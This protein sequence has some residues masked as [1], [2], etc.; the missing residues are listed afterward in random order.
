MK[1]N[2]RLNPESILSQRNQLLLNDAQHLLSSGKYT[3]SRLA[4]NKILR[5][6]PEHTDALLIKYQIEAAE[7]AYDAAFD[8]L[9]QLVDKHDLTQAQLLRLAAHLNKLEL[10]FLLHKVIHKL[11]VFS[12]EDN[13]LKFQQSLCLSKIGQIQ[14]SLELAL[15]CEKNDYENPLLFLNIGHNY[16]AFGNTDKAAEYYQKYITKCPENS[17]FGNWGL[18]DLKHYLF[19]QTE[20]EEMENKLRDV[21]LGKTENQAELIHFA[22][23]HAK[24]QQKS[25]QQALEHITI[26]NNGLSKLRPFR[27]QGYMQLINEL[28]NYCD[29]TINPDFTVDET[30][31]PI[32]IVGMPRSGTTLTEQILASHSKIA[33]TDEL[34]FI[35][36]I[37]MQM[38]RKRGYA[39]G[40]SEMTSAQRAGYIKFYLSQA[41]AYLDQKTPFLID[42][43]PTN[44]LHLGL[45][46]KLF[47]HAKIINLVRDPFDNAISVYKQHFSQG[48]DFSYDLN[49]IKHYVSGYIS[50][51]QHWTKLFPENVYHLHYEKL[52]SSPEKSISQL[53]EFCGLSIE[54]QCFEFFNSDK[55]V[56]TPS[57][58]QVRQPIHAKSLGSAG[59]YAEYLP[60]FKQHMD[61]LKHRMLDAFS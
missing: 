1:I 20:I 3:S 17:G 15:I 57:A 9:T 45:I 50:I 12:P 53:I 59:V 32:F 4:L 2:P 55:P 54:R 39:Q 46:I 30:L 5:K 21:N 42:K 58:S 8:Q 43:N 49:S 34:P 28:Q 25:Y 61:G 51:M 31:T 35:E 13:H 38:G 26:A 27:Q 14:T 29:N 19:S 36:R 18:A 47:P 37:A 41:S 60:E 11:I 23:G 6:E 10:Y 44:F 40:L 56:L 22:L 24:S 52:V 48:N 16:K 7:G 33:A